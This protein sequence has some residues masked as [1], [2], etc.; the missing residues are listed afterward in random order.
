M[1]IDGYNQ[2]I[3]K[4]RYA[5][6]EVTGEFKSIT[7]RSEDKDNS[8]PGVPLAEWIKDHQNE[9][10]LK[11]VKGTLIMFYLPSDIQG[12]GV[13]GYHVH[14]INAERTRGGHV[15]NA[16]ILNAIVIFQPLKFLHVYPNAEKAS[17][18]GLHAIESSSQH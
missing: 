4:A 9:F 1:K 11:D 16:D 10:T 8:K 15:L 13:P 5:A 3:L 7:F 14:F 2:S 12:V 17:L 18:H 6:V